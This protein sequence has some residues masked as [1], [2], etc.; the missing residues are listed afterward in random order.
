MLLLLLMLLLPMLLPMHWMHWMMVPRLPQKGHVASRGSL[1]L[2]RD[3]SGTKST[4]ALLKRMGT[5]CGMQ[6][7]H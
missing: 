4:P 6:G 5:E 1:Y 2:A 3:F 7:M